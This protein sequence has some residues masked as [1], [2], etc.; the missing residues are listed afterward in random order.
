MTEKMVLWRFI[1]PNDSTL[2]F[3]Y[4]WMGTHSISFKN[5]RPNAKLHL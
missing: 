2:Y 3:H 5:E 1:S 4:K